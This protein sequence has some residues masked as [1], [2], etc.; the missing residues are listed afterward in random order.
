MANSTSKLLT[1]GPPG[2]ERRCISTAGTGPSG[3][4]RFVDP[5]GELRTDGM[6]LLKRKARTQFMNEQEINN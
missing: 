5:K 1:L 4:Y 3:F 2:S 6:K